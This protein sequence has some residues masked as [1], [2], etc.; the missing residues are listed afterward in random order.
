MAWKRF[1]PCSPCC[2]PTIGY[3]DVEWEI[4]AV[5]CKPRY[6]KIVQMKD[7]TAEELAP[8][9]RKCAVVMAGPIGCGSAFANIRFDEE[10]WPTIGEWVAEGG[11]LFCWGEYAGCMSEDQRDDL[12]E[13]LSVI[14]STMSIGEEA[15][16]PFCFT[17]EGVPQDVPIMT[18][19]DVVTYAYTN[20]VIGGTTLAVTDPDGGCPGMPFLALEAVGAGFVM[21]AGD[22]NLFISCA[23][24]NC[25]LLNAFVTLGD[26][27]LL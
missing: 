5:C 16:D 20:E 12:N 18:G 25:D 7:M 17:R 19:I 11:R 10:V 26:E 13:F 24:G 14:G 23:P 6:N 9:L 27:E 4:A 2:C 22:G 15:C 21:F 8:A 1:N 3:T